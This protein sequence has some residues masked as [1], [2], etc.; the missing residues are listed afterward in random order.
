[1]LGHWGK[2]K[3]SGLQLLHHLTAFLPA[4]RYEKED[5]ILRLLP[6]AEVTLHIYKCHLG[7]CK[8]P[9]THERC[10]AQSCKSC[11]FYL[12][13]HASNLDQI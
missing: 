9:N 3:R 2:C 13:L 1:M 6:T 8:A 4:K 5:P 10:N 12:F 7:L 11:F